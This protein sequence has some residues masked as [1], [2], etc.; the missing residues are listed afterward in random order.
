[1]VTPPG[2]RRPG[3]LDRYPPPMAAKVWTALVAAACL[4]VVGAATG[5]A[6]VLLSFLIGLSE[7]ITSVT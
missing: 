5:L 7:L 4:A 6:L 1:M 2:A 3:P